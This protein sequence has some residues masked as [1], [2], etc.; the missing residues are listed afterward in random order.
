MAAPSGES[1]V[2]FVNS[3]NRKIEKKTEK[4][5]SKKRKRKSVRR[6]PQGGARTGNCVPD[7]PL[8]PKHLNAFGAALG[9]FKAGKAKYN[10]TKGCPLNLGED[11][12][13]QNFINELNSG[14][15]TNINTTDSM[16]ALQFLSLQDGC[17]GQLGGASES[18]PQCVDIDA[19][20]QEIQDISQLVGSTALVTQDLTIVKEG[21]DSSNQGFRALQEASRDPNET[22]GTLT[23]KVLSEYLNN[24]R[25]LSRMAEVFQKMDMGIMEEYEERHV[26]AG[27]ESAVQVTKQLGPAMAYIAQKLLRLTMWL[28]GSNVG[29][30]ILAYLFYDLWQTRFGNWLIRTLFGWVFKQL[31]ESRHGVR[32]SEF[33]EYIQTQLLGAGKAFIGSAALSAAMGKFATA[34]ANNPQAQEMMVKAIT[35]AGPDVAARVAENLTPAL[36]DAL[37]NAVAHQ[38]VSTSAVGTLQNGF[39]QVAQGMAMQLLQGYLGTGALPALTQG[40]TRRRRRRRRKKTRKV[41]RRARK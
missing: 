13:F 3:L 14:K 22:A 17:L 24:L 19:L 36:T 33:V 34:F 29:C 26:E 38:V 32:A 35:K 2:S 10:I 4:G 16:F 23:L 15:N 7:I 31:S 1:L 39:A 12:E 11:K 20:S 27:R 5:G 25:V 40:G 37:T 8:S 6:K 21:L 9:K 30:L 28:M 18:G 41:K